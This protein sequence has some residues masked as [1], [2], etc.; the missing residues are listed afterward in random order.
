MSGM[1]GETGDFHKD[2]NEG[3]LPES[4]GA[5]KLSAKLKRTTS[6]SLL[7]VSLTKEM[8]KLQQLTKS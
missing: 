1:S 8:R 3:R 4:V 5:K 7:F 6:K 2:M